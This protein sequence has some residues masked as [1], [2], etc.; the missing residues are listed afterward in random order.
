MREVEEQSFIEG[1]HDEN[2][3][4]DTSDRNLQ[5]LDTSLNHLGL[6]RKTVCATD[7]AVQWNVGYVDAIGGPKIV[8]CNCT[9]AIKSMCAEVSVKCNMSVECL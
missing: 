6:A 7:A 3:P 8:T 4:L 5:Q 1:S 2:L 9:N